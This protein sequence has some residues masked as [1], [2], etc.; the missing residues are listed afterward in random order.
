MVSKEHI[1]DPL[2]SSLILA[3]PFFWEEADGSQFPRLGPAHRYWEKY[4]TDTEEGHRLFESTDHPA[5]G[6][7]ANRHLH[8]I[9]M[10]EPQIITPRLGQGAFLLIVTDAYHRRCAI[11]GEKRC[12]FWMCGTYKALFGK[13]RPTRCEQW[14]F[15]APGFYIPCLTGIHN[16]HQRLCCRGKS[17]N[18]RRLWKRQRRI[19]PITGSSWQRCRIACWKGPRPNFFHGINENRYVG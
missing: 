17:S 15:A 3:T 9:G 7:Q 6:V 19:T 14:T 11:T 16:R 5:G 1:T 18:Q 2:V 13:K 12:Q 8:K 4:D 10:G